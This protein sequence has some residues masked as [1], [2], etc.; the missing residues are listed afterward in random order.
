M[1]TY[2]T[3]VANAFIWVVKS[4]FKVCFRRFF[5]ESAWTL[6]RAAPCNVA[7]YRLGLG[8]S[9]GDAFLDV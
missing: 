4:G 6:V 9:L 3:G 7:V 5:G 2:A 1:L 8:F